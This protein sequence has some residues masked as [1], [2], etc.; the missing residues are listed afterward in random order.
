MKWLIDSADV[1]I[2]LSPELPAVKP[3]N[4]AT[5]RYLSKTM[6]SHLSHWLEL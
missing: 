4:L 2:L 6:A 1:A 3:P 5:Q